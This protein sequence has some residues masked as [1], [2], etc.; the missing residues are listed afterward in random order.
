MAATQLPLLRPRLPQ[1]LLPLSPRLPQLLLPL[2]PRLPQLLRLTRVTTRPS[3][4]HARKWVIPRHHTAR[5]N[6]PKGLLKCRQV[7]LRQ[8]QPSFAPRSLRLSRR[9]LRS[10]T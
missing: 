1:L 4:V 7:R 9:T 8:L 5:T 6:R 3:T 2:R 10:K